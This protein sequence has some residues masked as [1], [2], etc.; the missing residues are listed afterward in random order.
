[1]GNVDLPE[2]LVETTVAQT[3]PVKPKLTPEEEEQLALKIKKH[4][5]EKA[6]WKKLCLAKFSNLEEIADHI[7]DS[8][9]E[10]YM[11]DGGKTLGK[12]NQED[13]LEK[14]KEAQS[15]KKKS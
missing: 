13:R 11:K 5:E 3:E 15:Q 9:V 1:M 7:L 6:H 14:K 12:L 10:I 8:I 2:P 4:E